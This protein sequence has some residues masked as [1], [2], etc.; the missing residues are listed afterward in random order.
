MAV[1]IFPLNC[2]EGDSMNFIV[3]CSIMFNQGWSFPPIYSYMFDMQPLAVYLIVA[4]KHILP[5]F[6]CDQIYC[7]LTAISAYV[8]LVGCLKFV[9]KMTGSNKILI[10]F[11][12]FLLPESYACA[13]YPNTTTLAYPFFVWALY[14]LLCKKYWKSVALM[15]IAPLFRIDVI[16]VY[17]V[18]VGIL[19]Y[20]HQPIKEVIIKT[21]LAAVIVLTVMTC[22]YELLGAHPLNKTFLSYSDLNKTGICSSEV[23]YSVITFFSINFLIIPFGLYKIIKEKN[24]LLLLVLAIP[25][26]LL[27]YL[28]RNTATA[29]KHWLYILPFVLVFCVKGWGFIYSKIKERGILKW[30]VVLGVILFTI[31]SIRIDVP[32]KP[33]RSKPYSISTIGPVLNLYN[34]NISQYRA[35]FGIGAGFKIATLDEI[36]LLSGNTFYPFYIHLYKQNNEIIF[37]NFYNVI[38]DY[39]SRN[40]TLDIA[41][42][43]SNDQCNMLIESGW[44]FCNYNAK[45]QCIQLKKADKTINYNMS[46]QDSNN[47]LSSNNSSKNATSTNNKKHEKTTL[48]MTSD[49]KVVYYYDSLTNKNRV[50]KL[51]FGCYQIY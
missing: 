47:L 35:H 27:G 43:W 25:I 42:E 16:I 15:C 28:F 7:L 13:M 23:K 19:L 11:S 30:I 26:I 6:G 46:N 40:K 9:Q 51:T 44:R 32:S 37:R 31:A 24:Y 29:A 10:L 36:M 1:G 49:E 4:L 45:E 34:T 8:A 39:A 22:I 14:F 3:G 33:W 12:I 17:P 41:G 18:I 21:L 2:Y 50:K 48:I 38:V 5:F 20:Q